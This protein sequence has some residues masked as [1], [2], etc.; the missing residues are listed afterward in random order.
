MA[1][2]R[3]FIGSL[4][5]TGGEDQRDGKRIEWGVGGSEDAETTMRMVLVVN[6]HL[7]SGEE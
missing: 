5:F 7:C 6:I 3:C 4:V 1:P 2:A